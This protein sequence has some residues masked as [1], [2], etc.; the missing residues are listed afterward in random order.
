[1]AS[2]SEQGKRIETLRAIQTIKVMGAETQREGDWANRFAETIRTGQR[3]AFANIGFSSIQGVS[4]TI[5]SVA[6][7][8]L[9]A[10]AIIENTMTVGILYAFMAYKGQFTSRA[11]GLFETFVGWRMLDL[12][13][14]RIADIALT[15]VEKGIDDTGYGLPAMAGAVELRNLAFQYAPHEPMIFQNVTLRLKAGEFIAIAGPSGG[16]KSTLVKVLCG[17]Y[18]ATTGEIRIDDLPLSSWGPRG[19]RS[20]LGVVLQDDELISGSIAENVAFFAED[21]DMDRVWSCLEMAAIHEE[22]QAMPM[23]ADTFVGDMGSSLSG[24]QKQRILLARALYRQPRILVLD[25][26]TSHLDIARERAI[27][28]AIKAQTITRI[29]VAHRPETIAAADRVLVLQNGRLVEA[30]RTPLPSTEPAG[31]SPTPTVTP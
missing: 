25:E 20:N 2:I 4:D 17:L 11:Q 9:G 3:N 8:Y 29:I 31:P 23:R 30:R 19:V 28:D 16:G 10:T 1:M 21:I 24:G 26:A 6:I 18:P 22:I 13:S 12:H 7:I 14:D 15:P 5:A 27:N